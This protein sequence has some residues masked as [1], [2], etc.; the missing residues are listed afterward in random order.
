MAKLTVNI[1]TSA[2]DR[3]GDNLRTAF[4]KINQNFDELYT[5]LGLDSDGTLNLGNFVFE[6]NTVRLT[7]ANNDDS[8]ATQIQ[9]A[10]PVR[11]ESDLTVGGDVV[12]ST[13]FGSSLGSSTK[14]F[15]D[16]YLSGN[17]ITLGSE[18][19]S[20][21]TGKIILSGAV[22]ASTLTVTSINATNVTGS[23]SGA[24]NIKSRSDGG[25]NILT[26]GETMTVDALSI[27]IEN[28]DG[29]RANAGESEIFIKY[30][31]PSLSTEVSALYDSASIGAPVF[32]GGKV[33]LESGNTTYTPILAPLQA[34]GMMLTINLAD[35]TTFKLYRITVVARD[36]NDGAGQL[37]TA[38]AT[39]ETLK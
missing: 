32:G 30:S 12:P 23:F 6:N 3:T 38:I 29:A 11:I 8:T 2:N 20:S 37:A 35:H 26:E 19:I 24:V 28:G 7:N 27:K 17:T 15:K 14:R 13:D 9:I 1:G 18:T 25:S 39:I 5:E 16:L 33:T 21:D 34:A 31:H 36:L 10:Q 4:N 22:E